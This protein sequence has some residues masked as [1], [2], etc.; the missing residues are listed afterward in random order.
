MVPGKRQCSATNLENTGHGP[1]ISI[2]REKEHQDDCPKEHPIND[3]ELQTREMGCEGSIVTAL[4]WVE[5]GVGPSHNRVFAR[6]GSG[7][8]MKIVMPTDENESQKSQ[9]RH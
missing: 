2:G 4:A 8:G 1:A 3:V 7:R 9:L 5:I 6:G